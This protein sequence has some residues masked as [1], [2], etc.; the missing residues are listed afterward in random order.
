M[1]DSTRSFAMKALR[2]HRVLEGNEFESVKRERDILISSRHHP[3]I[4]HVYAVFHDF[5][6]IYFLLEYAPC[7]AFYDFLLRCGENFDEPCIQWFSGQ[8]ICALSYLHSQ[9]IVCLSRDH[10]RKV[11][12]CLDPSGLET[13]KCS[14][15][16]RWP[17]ETCR[18]W[19]CK[20]DEE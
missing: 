8:I 16:A 11:F 6:R 17:L 2:K 19:F 4:I 15:N 5:E 10:D 9:L 13:G 3:F 20:D 7:G 1:K 12:I 14:P 18:F